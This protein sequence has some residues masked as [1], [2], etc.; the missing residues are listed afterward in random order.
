VLKLLSEQ[1]KDRVAGHV[2]RCGGVLVILVV[3]GMIVNIGL[4]TLPLFRG[5]RA[6][7]IGSVVTAPDPMACGSSSR[8]DAAWWLLG[9]GTIEVSLG[10]EPSH[11]RIGAGRGEIVAADHEIH[12]L[13]SMIDEKGGVELGRVAFVDRWQDGDRSTQPAWRPASSP[14]SFGDSVSWR[15]VTANADR[16]GSALAAAWGE[17]VGVRVARW[18][19]DA[20]EW[21]A[22]I[23]LDTNEV[24]SAAIAE[25]LGAVAVVLRSGRLRLF[26]ER[27]AQIRELSIEGMPASVAAARFLL[28]GMSLV[29]AGR[30]GSIH[31]ALRVPRVEVANNGRSTLR[32]G[33]AEIPPGD[34]AVVRDD[35]FAYRFAGRDDIVVETAE[36]V[37]RVVRSLDSMPA[38]PTVI[39]PSHRRHG[40]VVGDIEGHVALYHATSGRLL[41][42]DRWSEHPVASLAMAPRGD[43]ILAVASGELL[44]RSV[45]N[46][47]P[48]ISLR[49][50]FLPIWYEDYGAPRWV[51]QT[52]G[53]SDTFEPKFSIW[54]LLFGTLKATFYAMLVSAPLALMAALYV[55]Q[56]APRWLQA[57]VKPTVELMAAVPS[58]VVGFLAALWLAPRL[59]EFLLQALLAFAALPLA[60]VVALTSWRSLPSKLRHRVPAGSELVV[61]LMSVAVMVAAIVL[62]ADPI[63]RWLF[64]GD[65]QR[66]LFTELGIRYEQRNSFVVG[67]A[68][69]F[70]VIPVMFTIAEDACSAV[71]RSLVRAARALGA[72]RWQA[73]IRLVTPAASP[74][75][76][77]AVMLGLGRAVGETMIVLMAAGN[78]P[79]LDVSPFNGMRTMSAAIAFE[80]PEAAVGGTLFR[81]LFLTGFLLFLFSLLFTTAADVVGRR[82]RRRYARF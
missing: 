77:A 30:D 82:L 26:Q 17:G 9:D 65:F 78:T 25:D 37:W 60:V 70:A 51:W 8:R 67:V 52:T 69:G 54:P 5:A 12:G 63:E 11:V 29:V 38:R 24:E 56:L 46:P 4:Q 36:P 40:F 15:G 3:T 45:W 22:P 18:S 75:L 62:I 34:A 43:G 50:L 16:D 72:T 39:A 58:V 7:E 76:F 32:L 79:I 61:L 19:A 2:I 10:G 73:A 41:L 81:V 55:S 35:G 74:G 33:G 44:R 68:L 66:F 57:V 49:T 21:N 47:H 28:G 27:G 64:G 42:R 1:Q 53:G 6:G 71:P 80:I 20:E 14:Y 31:V 48:E 13:L 59:Q 23:T